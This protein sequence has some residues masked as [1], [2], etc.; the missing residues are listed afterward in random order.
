[1]MWCWF[2]LLCSSQNSCLLN[3][4]FIPITEAL[5]HPLF[6]KHISLNCESWAVFLALWA[7]SCV[8][9]GWAVKCV[10]DLLCSAFCWALN[11]HVMCS[12]NKTCVFLLPWMSK[13]SCCKQWYAISYPPNLHMLVC[14]VQ[15]IVFWHWLQKPE[16]KKPP[17]KQKPDR[18]VKLDLEKGF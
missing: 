3:W 9:A 8:E 5:G 4:I 6:N 15:F 12:S 18:I 1:M 14:Q 17:S 13:T 10:Q 2:S 7:C 16:G 11:V